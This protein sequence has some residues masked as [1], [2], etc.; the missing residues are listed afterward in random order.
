[1]SGGRSKQRSKND[2]IQESEAS[3]PAKCKNCWDPQQGKPKI[4]AYQDK[5]D[6]LTSDRIEAAR[7]NEFPFQNQH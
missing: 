3:E 2:N 7:T 4:G 5:E 1:M 6:N